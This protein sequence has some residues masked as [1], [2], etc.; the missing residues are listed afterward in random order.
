MESPV[1]PVS[2]VSNAFDRIT[3]VAPNT[4]KARLVSK[5]VGR[6][7]GQK[8]DYELP[9][10]FAQE[11]FELSKEL[12]SFSFIVIPKSYFNREGICSDLNVFVDG[13]QSILSEVAL[14]LRKVA[15]DQPV[16]PEVVFMIGKVRVGPMEALTIQKLE[17]QASVLALR[18]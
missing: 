3:L 4:V 10:D 12:L 1:R 6:F 8:W 14:L 17:L 11:F 16:A 9:E 2:S 13:S 15:T 18:L 7:S 5:V